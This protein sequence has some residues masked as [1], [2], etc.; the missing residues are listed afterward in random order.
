MG[1]FGDDYFSKIDSDAVR[2][3]IALSFEIDDIVKKAV[4]THSLSPQNIESE[5]RKSLLPKLFEIVGLESAKEAIDRVV[6]ITRVGLSRGS[7]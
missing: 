7:L 5:I 1:C 3:F 2:S 6:Q 4:A